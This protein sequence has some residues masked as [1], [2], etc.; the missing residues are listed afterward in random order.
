MKLDFVR[1]QHNGTLFNKNLLCIFL[2]QSYLKLFHSIIQTYKRPNQL[3]LHFLLFAFLPF[4]IVRYALQFQQVLIVVSSLLPA[5]K[6]ISSKSLIKIDSKKQIGKQNLPVAHMRE[7]P[8]YHHQLFVVVS[9][10]LL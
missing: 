6:K 5:K 4:Y 10:R 9:L 7:Q 1:F 3:H 2:C 8:L